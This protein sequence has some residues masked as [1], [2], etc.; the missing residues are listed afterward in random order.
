MKKVISFIFLLITCIS[1]IN[2]T[3]E[4]GFVSG[5]VK[6]ISLEGGFYGING[7]NNENYDPINLPAGFKV[8]GLKIKFKYK[9][10]DEQASFHMWGTLIELKIVEKIIY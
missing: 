4:A 7:D 9:I 1:C 10:C 2:D 8:D 6:Y 3:D 5:T